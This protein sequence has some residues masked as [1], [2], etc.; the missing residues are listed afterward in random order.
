MKI[1]VTSKGNALDSPV[2]PHFGRAKGF[3]AADTESGA[4]EFM[5]GHWVYVWT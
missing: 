1:A 3:I 5:E 4:F 2:D